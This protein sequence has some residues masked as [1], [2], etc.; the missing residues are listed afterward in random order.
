MTARYTPEEIKY[1]NIHRDRA[2]ERLGINQSLYNWGRR[3]AEELRKVYEADCN[4]M[5]QE[6][7]ERDSITEPIEKAIV[8]KFAGL[9]VYFQGDCRGATL[10]VDTEPISDSAYTNAV[11]IY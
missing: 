6:E 5:F 3:K 8:A 7:G 2:C 1:Y 9:H 4:G 10:Y 11:C